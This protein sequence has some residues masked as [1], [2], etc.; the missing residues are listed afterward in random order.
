MDFDTGIVL[1]G[2]NEEDQRVPA[3]MMKMVAVH[4]VYDEIKAGR[5]SLNSTV[6]VR[7]ATSRFSYNMEYSNVPLPEGSAFSVRSLLEAV[8][9][10]SAC[11]ATV[12]LSESIFGDESVLVARMNAKA[13][14][15]GVQARFVDCWGG[16][17]DN[18]ISALGTAILTRAL[19]MDHPEVLEIASKSSFVFNGATYRTSNLLL[20]EYTGL[21]GLKTGFTNP[22]GYC[23]IGTAK[24]GERRLISV[25]MGATMQSRYPDTRTLLD[26]GFAVADRTIEEYMR[27]Q[28]ARPSSA[29]LIINGETMPLTAYL[30]ND[31][32]YFK[33][34]DIAFLLTDTNKK[35]EVTWSS[36]Y[37]MIT[38]TSGRSYSADGNELSVV[39]E[40]PRPYIPTP[41]SMFYDE[42][43]CEF[44][45][46][47]IDGFNHF[48]LRDLAD[49]IGF[50]VIWEG[51]TSTVII[52]TNPDDTEET[53]E[54][55]EADETEEEEPDAKPEDEDGEPDD[56]LN[57]A[58]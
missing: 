33:L 42:I 35:F 2:H 56:E 16:S 12:A 3:S 26:Y 53:E 32:H 46:Y 29:N 17:P 7:P 21:D 47:L 25:V 23:F 4:I 5:L 31:Y 40:G 20:G 34:R 30:I 55:D 50:E 58:A 6:R 57:E 51:A 54:T 28:M 52:N 10:R 15:L 8:I 43:E 49:L 45:S 14:E 48:K 37:N 24:R 19:I 18:R 11:A 1:F 9:I 38:L 36:A 41:S 44:E 39:A 27:T 22:A 13:R